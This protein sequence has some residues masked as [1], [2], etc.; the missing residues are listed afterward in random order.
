MITTPTEINKDIFKFCEEI[1]P[2]AKPVFLEFFHV[3]GYIG[4]ECYGNVEKH[5]EKNGGRVQ[6][7]WIIWGD[8][9]IF[10]EAEFHAVWI[11]DE[12]EYIDLTPKADG[13]K[14]IL[15]LPD[16]KRKFTGELIDNIRK[17]LVDNAYTRTLI[18]VGERKFEIRKKYYLGGHMRE[19][20]KFELKNL[21]DYDKKVYSEELLKDKLGGKIKI[22]R[23]ESCP[24]GSGKKYKK[25]C[26]TS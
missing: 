16:S 23:N 12:G 21:E 14:R 22:G 17:S 4:G 8:N 24:C 15:F 5:I 3:E 25:C 26:G 18:K 10:L 20:P 19:I 11:N 2:T 9:N 13:E 1:D 7:G 6:Y